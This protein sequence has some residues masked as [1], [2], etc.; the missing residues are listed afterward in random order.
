[1]T[2][3]LVALA[4][5]AAEPAA[6][7]PLRSAPPEWLSAAGRAAAEE[8][9]SPEAALAWAELLAREASLSAAS[10]AC[11]GLARRWPRAPQA[12]SAFLNAARDALAAGE[13]DRAET[14]LGEMRER[15]PRGE[16]AL[17]RDQASLAVA[18]T[19]LEAAS[20]GALAEASARRQAQLAFKS[21]TAMI[22]RDRAGP[23]AEPAALGRA[24]AFL[25]LGNRGKAIQALENFLNAYPR[26]DLV[27]EARRLL[28]EATSTRARGKSREGDALAEARDSAE[29]ARQQAAPAPFGTSAIDETYRAIAARQAELKID[30][31]RLYIRLKKPRAAEWVLRS[32]LR[33]YGDT[34]SAREAAE[35]LE[36]L[37]GE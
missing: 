13:F 14:L 33:R 9:A 24:R 26:S 10:R 37:A 28:A 8:A 17:Q 4:M 1:M 21:F 19:R 35:L 6:S 25:A 34:P 30:E 22:E 2:G 3:L 31:A 7:A 20:G 16:L 18:E 12:E 23:C 27:P 29:W 15:W 36:E 32:V 5:L 11:E